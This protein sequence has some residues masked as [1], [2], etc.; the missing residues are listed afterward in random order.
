MPPRRLCKNVKSSLSLLKL[1]LDKKKLAKDY[2]PP[3]YPD[4]VLI[5]NRVFCLRVAVCF[6]VSLVVIEN[7]PS[8]AP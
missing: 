7:Y 8:K 1:Q 6:F 3:T 2:P 5:V 4:Q